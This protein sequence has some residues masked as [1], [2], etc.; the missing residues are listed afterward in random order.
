M[1]KRT[2]ATRGNPHAAAASIGRELRSEVT[3]GAQLQQERVL[4]LELVDGRGL[5]R[6][7]AE[8]R[9]ACELLVEV[10]PLP[11]SRERQVLDRGPAGEQ[12]ELRH[13]EVRIAGEGDR[14]T[15]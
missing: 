10:E 1:F 4:I 5:R 2:V 8:G 15:H 14:A 11:F 7:R 12:A 3:L 6:G 13:V 9:Y